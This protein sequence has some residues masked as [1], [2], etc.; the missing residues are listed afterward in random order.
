MD[1]ILKNR[2]NFN[3]NPEPKKAPKKALKKAEHIEKS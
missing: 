1:I 2:G 3:K